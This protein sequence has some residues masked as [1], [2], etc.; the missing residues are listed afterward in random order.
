MEGVGEQGV[1]NQAPLDGPSWSLSHHSRHAYC[2][3]SVPSQFGAQEGEWGGNEASAMSDGEAG[4]GA[5]PLRLD[6]QP[7]GLLMVAEAC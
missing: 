6:A 5:E 2:G 4:S 3:G 7:S 1:P